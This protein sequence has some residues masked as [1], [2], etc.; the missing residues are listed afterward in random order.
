VV[1]DWRA[2]SRGGGVGV[3]DDGSQQMGRVT[4]ERRRATARRH[5]SAHKK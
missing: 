4:L 3:E 2:R 1:D 5:S